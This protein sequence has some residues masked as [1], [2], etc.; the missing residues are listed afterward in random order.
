MVGRMPR[1]SKKAGCGDERPP[2]PTAVPSPGPAL[3]PS[4]EAAAP[5]PTAPPVDPASAAPPVKTPPA[6]ASPSP[7]PAL[8]GTAPPEPP[9]PAP[10]DWLQG[11]VIGPQPLQMMVPIDTP[12]KEFMAVR[13]HVRAKQRAQQQRHGAITPPAFPRAAEPA[14]GGAPRKMDATKEKLCR[15][16]AEHPECRGPRF[17]EARLARLLGQWYGFAATPR[18]VGRALQQL[19]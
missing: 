8:V 13:R 5:A 12:V 16:F 9:A 15:L 7:A 4:P 14:R 3:A 11:P 1:R 19:R 6:P 18:T 2:S 17:G 10:L